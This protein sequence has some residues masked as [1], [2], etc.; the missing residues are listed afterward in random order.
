M[1]FRI[2]IEFLFTLAFDY[3]EHS[4]CSQNTGPL[5]SN[6]PRKDHLL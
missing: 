2:E 5:P 3:F 4:A 6:P 1:R